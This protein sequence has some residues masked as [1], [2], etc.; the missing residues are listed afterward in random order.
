MTS[1]SRREL[2]EEWIRARM[3]EKEGHNLE[4]K[5]AERSMDL[6]ALADYCVAIANEGGGYLFL[7][8]T[9][10]YPRSIVGSSALRSPGKTERKLLDILHQRIDVTPVITSEGRVVVVTIPPRPI[11]APLHHKGRYLVRSDDAVV[12]MTSWQLQKIFAESTP[13]YSALTCEGAVRGDLDADAVERF[14]KGWAR[15]E[16]KSHRRSHILSQTVEELLEDAELIV[17]GNITYAALILLGT[18]KAVKRFIPQA[19]VI[20][21][22]RSTHSPGPAQQRLEYRS[23]FLSFDDRLWQA[24]DIR[25]ENLHFQE[26]MFVGAIPVFNEGVIRE[27]IANAISHRDYRRGASV[28]IRQYPRLLQVD[29]PGGFPEGISPRNFLTRNDPRNRRIAEN[30]SRCGV[31]E[32]AGQGIGLMFRNSILEGKNEPDYT[33]T[34]E[35]HVSVRLSGEV[36]NPRFIAFVE[37]VNAELGSAVRVEDLI[38]ASR[39]YR[40]RPIGEELRPRIGRLVDAGIIERM[41]GARSRKVMLSERFYRYLGEP[42]AYTRKRGLGKEAEKE[43]LVAHLSTAGSQG[44]KV[45]ELAQ[46]LPNRQ[47][48]HI[49][50]LMQELK[51]AGRVSVEGR[52]RAGRWRIVDKARQS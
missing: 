34:D 45:E 9:D 2:T 49:S 42:G 3:D 11:G 36:E 38:I 40:E 52:T 24:I 33:G 25:N 37:E 6:E 7:G 46:V 30:L 15:R 20:F 29:S 27:A 8:I 5:R 19:E 16:V 26:G 47:R 4:F 17:G 32:R 13:D 23:G 12:P 43:L 51:E 31:V 18:A 41:G 1:G 21:E 44:A 39:A 28:F 10:R 14:R 48:R 22:Y 50:R 35:H